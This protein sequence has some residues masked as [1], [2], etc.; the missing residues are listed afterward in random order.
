MIKLDSLI[1]IPGNFDSMLALY[2]VM[3]SLFRKDLGHPNECNGIIGKA[4]CPFSL[5]HATEIIVYS[6]SNNSEFVIFF[7]GMHKLTCIFSSVP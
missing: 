2:I 6:I 4:T 5:G 7:H 3:L 1:N